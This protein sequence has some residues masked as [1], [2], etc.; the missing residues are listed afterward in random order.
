[1]I[2][3]LILVILWVIPVILGVFTWYSAIKENPTLSIGDIIIFFTCLLPIFG[4]VFFVCCFSDKLT[5]KNPF[6]K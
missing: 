2:E 4:M 1:M 6:K 5:F 3:G